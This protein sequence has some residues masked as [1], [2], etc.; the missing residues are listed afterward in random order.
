MF[1]KTNVVEHV[2]FVDVIFKRKQN[3]QPRVVLK[4]N[5]NI[6]GCNCGKPKQKTTIVD[7]TKQ[8]VR[9]LWEKSQKEEKPFNVTKINKK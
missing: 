6:M 4:I 5:G 9:N 1:V 8:V 7:K 2:V 3:G